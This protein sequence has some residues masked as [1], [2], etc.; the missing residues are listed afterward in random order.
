MPAGLETGAPISSG[1]GRTALED[2]PKEDVIVEFLTE[3]RQDAPTESERDMIRDA[4]AGAL[5]S[6]DA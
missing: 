4:L 1:P 2:Q 6:A 5:R 3:L